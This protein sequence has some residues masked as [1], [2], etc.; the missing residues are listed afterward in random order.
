MNGMNKGKKCKQSIFVQ[1]R[2]KEEG[3]KSE[4]TILREERVGE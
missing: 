2:K 3:K 4:Q 1:Q